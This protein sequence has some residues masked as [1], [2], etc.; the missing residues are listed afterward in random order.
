KRTRF[1]T[2]SDATGQPL[3]ARPFIDP[4][5]GGFGALLVSFPT[6]AS[7]TATVD[8][9]TQIFG[10]EVNAVS[11][12]YR[13][14]PDEGVCW[15][16]NALVGF[17]YVQLEERLAIAQ[18]TVILPGQTAPFDGKSYTGPVTIGVSDSFFAQ[19][20]F[21]GGQ[22]GFA[23]EAKSGKA[24]FRLTGKVA[25]GYIHQRVIVD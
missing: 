15:S 1:T 22:V 9:T 16:L 10:Y 5:T 13:S 24:F 25:A 11:N 20:R 4:A 14:F 17:R 2:G 6:F 23:A 7:G 21:Y 3:I 12:W 18:T 8:A 19:N